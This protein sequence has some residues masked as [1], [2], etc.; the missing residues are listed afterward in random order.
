MFTYANE[1]S[2]WADCYEF[3][4]AH[5]CSKVNK[6]VFP[7]SAF[8]C[9]VMHIDA[10]NCCYWEILVSSLFVFGSKRQTYEYYC[11]GNSHR[12]TAS[13]HTQGKKTHTPFNANPSRAHKL[14]WCAPQ[15]GRLPKF[16]SHFCRDSNYTP[17]VS[18]FLSRTDSNCVWLDVF[19]T[20]QSKRLTAWL[21]LHCTSIFPYMRRGKRCHLPFHGV[22]AFWYSPKYL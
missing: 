10:C 2:K 18:T 14:C 5:L 1:I 19:S 8:L 21:K 15:R 4:W 12:E 7:S 17:T 13:L 20:G 16:L 3:H 11:R 6:S 9:G 22:L